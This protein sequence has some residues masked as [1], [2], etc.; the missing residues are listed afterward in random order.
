MTEPDERSVDE[1]KR[2]TTR[3]QRRAQAHVTAE[4]GQELAEEDIDRQVAML[5]QH[6]LEATG[7]RRVTLFRPVPRGQRW[8]S[9]TVLDDGNFY[10]GL[11]APDT[12]VLPMVAYTQKKPVLMGP[13]RPHEIPAPRPEQLGFRS[14]LGLPLL[15]G[16]EVV[17]V[18][19][20]VD[21]AQSELLERYATT[22]N[23]AL[24]ALTAALQ[25]DNRRQPSAAIPAPNS[26]H[27]L[28]V[29]VV[30]D[31]VLRLP[32][33]PDDLF[34]VAPGEW[35]VLVAIDGK[36]SLRDVATFANLPTEMV[37]GIAARLQERGLI[38]LAR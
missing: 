29:A 25:A 10:Y 31:L 28:D 38:R 37:T 22:L 23:E 2:Y 20:A 8:H 17:A 34:E 15:D 11:I 12:L 6:A 35:T 4:L 36:R 21:V 19:E 33:D 13:D 1:R 26:A 18:L 14:Y 3:L 30:M 5:V 16:T 24:T 9:V 27:G 32:F 7:A